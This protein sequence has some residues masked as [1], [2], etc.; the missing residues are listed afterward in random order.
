VGR[1]RGAPSLPH[2]KE[3]DVKAE[4]LDSIERALGIQLP[5]VYRSAAEAGR[6]ERRLNADA[7]SVIA[8]NLAFRAGEFGD[9]DWPHDKFAFAD[10]GSGNF[11]CL[12]LSSPEGRH[13]LCRDHETL[14]LAPE[15][16]DFERW[17]ETA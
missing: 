4:E 1:H 14:E 6:L 11:F 8:I 15:A 16:D 12:D 10:D 3:T 5:G 17:L 9:R 13:V 7:T 2:F